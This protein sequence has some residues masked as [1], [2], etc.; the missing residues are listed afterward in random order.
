MTM[1]RFTLTR[2]FMPDE[3]GM[4][5]L[6]FSDVQQWL[7][8]FNAGPLNTDD[9]QHRFEPPE[10]G[11]LAELQLE[12]RNTAV[13]AAFKLAWLGEAE[14]VEQFTYGKLRERMEKPLPGGA[15][16]RDISRL[17]RKRVVLA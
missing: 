6:N 5:H 8:D 11:I 14:Q 16:R 9:Y 10:K 1:T 2:L 17:C 12:F 4:S 15:A 3:T 13:A 7:A